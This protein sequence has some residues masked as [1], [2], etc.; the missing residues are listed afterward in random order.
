MEFPLS[1][2]IRVY[3]ERF[4]E[5]HFCGTEHIFA[6]VEA[7]SFSVEQGSK[8]YIIKEG[9]GMVFRKNIPYFR[10]VLSP[11]SVHLFRYAT[12]D[13][14]FHQEHIRFADTARIR[15]TLDAL[16]RAENA[17]EKELL[18]YKAHLFADL[19]Y[20]HWAESELFFRREPNDDPCIR[21]AVKRIHH[22]LHCKISLAA[23]ANE[24][25][26]SYAHFFRRF[27]AFTGRNPSD[28]IILCRLQKAKKLLMDP[29]LSIKS[30]AFSCGFENEYYFS[31]FFKKH[32]GVSP[33]L[34]RNSI[35]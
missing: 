10:R 25:G 4:R 30:I 29:S 27:Q 3:R 13:P 20:Q 35:I 19:V 8:K 14:L 18:S 17:M 21:Q 11:V 6:L 9:E 22:S 12:E 23:L 31:N 7:G 15:S 24:C 16:E 1:V 2:H 34:F 28:Y 26:L 5:E 32:A 33:S